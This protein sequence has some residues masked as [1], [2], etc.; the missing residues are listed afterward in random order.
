MKKFLITVIAS[1]VLVA[2]ILIPSAAFAQTSTSQAVRVESSAC[3]EAQTGPAL[4]EN[5][6]FC[7]NLPT[8][9]IDGGLAY[10]AAES[11]AA[12]ARVI[13][14]TPI[15]DYP[16]VDWGG[17]AITYVEFSSG[18][19]MEYSGNFVSIFNQQNQRV[20]GYQG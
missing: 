18:F 6:L 7:Q 15:N 14:G 13:V 10:L 17:H 1:I 3:G 4:Q 2:A 16:S 12:N 19:H 20:Y 11:A 9:I 5:D 8:G